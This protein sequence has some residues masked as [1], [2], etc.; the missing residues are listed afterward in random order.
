VVVYVLGLEAWL[1][2]REIAWLLPPPG[3]VEALE[4]DGVGVLAEV[5]GG[6]AVS[7]H[8]VDEQQLAVDDLCATALEEADWALS[9]HN[10]ACAEPDPLGR[11]VVHAELG[12][13]SVR[14]AGSSSAAVIASRPR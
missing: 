14:A 6:Y 12:E 1:R 4:P 7:H 9:R 2:Q 10:T 13:S 11:V 8:L 3:P 5:D